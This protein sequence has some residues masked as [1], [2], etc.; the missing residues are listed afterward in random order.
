MNCGRNRR[1]GNRI[2]SHIHVCVAISW[3]SRAVCFD[4]S[5]DSIYFCRDQAGDFLKIGCLFPIILIVIYT[6]L[7]PIC[8]KSRVDS[9]MNR[10]HF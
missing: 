10:L 8:V 4:V 3:L 5:S 2:R 1:S 6:M 9:S 7:A